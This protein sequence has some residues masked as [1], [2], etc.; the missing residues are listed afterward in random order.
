MI[1]V[2][3]IPSVM[4]SENR[5]PTA[6]IKKRPARDNGSTLFWGLSVFFFKAEITQLKAI[7]P[8]PRLVPKGDQGRESRVKLNP[9][10]IILFGWPN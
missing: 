2:A 4:L 3:L 1:I 10:A 6:L 5:I 9:R 8:I 7:M